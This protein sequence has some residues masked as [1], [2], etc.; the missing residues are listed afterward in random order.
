MRAVL[1]LSR[2]MRSATP[3]GGIH[4]G[5]LAVLA[6]LKRVGPLPAA[7]LAAE[8]RIAP[9]SLTRLIDDL[10]QRGYVSKERGPV[11]RRQVIVSPTEAGLA[12]LKANFRMRRQWLQSA[13]ST[14]LSQDEQSQLLAATVLLNHLARYQGN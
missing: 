11:D 4:L 3:H 2:A 5:G 7:Q 9:Q 8:Q 6:T 13:M 1:A 14:M 10:L 12:A